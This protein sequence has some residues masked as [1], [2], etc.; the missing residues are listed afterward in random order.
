M[1]PVNNP[2]LMLMQT[3]RNELSSTLTRDIS[4]RRQVG[5]GKRAIEGT[6]KGRK[7]PN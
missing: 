7:D 2:P 1:V 6:G 5:R 3:V 4:V